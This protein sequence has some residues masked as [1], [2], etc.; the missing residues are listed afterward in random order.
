MD[1]I[2][3]Q[4]QLASYT[5]GSLT[6][7]QKQRTTIRGLIN[8]VQARY[9]VINDD[10]NIKRETYEEVDRMWTVFLN[11]KNKLLKVYCFNKIL[12]F[13]TNK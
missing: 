4:A 5:I 3:L 8:R 11:K 1:D 13:C 10:L 9:D 6:S 7:Q 12:V 2:L